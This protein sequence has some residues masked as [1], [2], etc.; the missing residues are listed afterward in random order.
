MADPESCNTPF[1]HAFI[2][3]EDYELFEEIIATQVKTTFPRSEAIDA[4][5][6]ELGAVLR[7]F[8]RR[9][10]DR[11]AEIAGMELCGLEIAYFFTDLFLAPDARTAE[12]ART[13]AE[14]LW[15]QGVEDVE[16][17]KAA[18]RRRQIVRSR[19]G[20][21]EARRLVSGLIREK[22]VLKDAEELFVSV[23]N[24]IG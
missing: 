5:F 12:D 23:S 8:G 3:P 2:S 24:V 13:Y 21:E 19:L 20:L 10:Q 16:I 15:E 11:L 4:Q 22:V 14:D 1:S 17:A 18:T 6:K 9:E 7:V